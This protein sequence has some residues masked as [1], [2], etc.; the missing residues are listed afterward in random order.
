MKCRFIEHLLH[1]FIKLKGKNYVYSNND[2]EC[3]ICM[4]F[5]KEIIFYPCRHFYCCTLCSKSF[6]LCPICRSIILFK[7]NNDI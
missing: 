1:F 5:N 4:E 7:I 6:D 3:A 2:D